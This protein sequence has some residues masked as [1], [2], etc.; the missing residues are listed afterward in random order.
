M[1]LNTERL[2]KKNKQTPECSRYYLPVPIRRNANR[3]NAVFF[4]LGITLPL[5]CGIPISVLWK[6][7]IK[8]EWKIYYG[9]TGMKTLTSL[10]YA[11]ASSLVCSCTPTR[12]TLMPVFVLS[13]AVSWG[14]LKH[15]EAVEEN[16]FLL[17]ALGARALRADVLSRGSLAHCCLAVGVLALR[18]GQLSSFSEAE[19]LNSHSG[20]QSPWESAEYTAFRK[21]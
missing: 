2:L 18:Q 4:L 14:W 1:Q 9:I 20:P 21:D 13:E 17:A 7:G 15:V 12:E 3:L 19:H 11:C 16:R 8:I 10:P 5:V 6:N